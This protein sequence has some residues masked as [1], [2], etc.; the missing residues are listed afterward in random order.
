[1][2][3]QRM[4]GLF[5]KRDGK[6]VRMYPCLAYTKACAIRLFQ[7]ELLAGCFG[8]ADV[9]GVRELRPLPAVKKEANQ[10]ADQVRSGELSFTDACRGIL[11]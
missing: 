10:I 11:R 7:N 4:Y 2:K 3:Q 5:E 8:G 6:W 9:Q 1:M